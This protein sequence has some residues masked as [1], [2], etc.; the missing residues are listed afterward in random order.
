MSRIAIRAVKLGKTYRIGARQE[1]Y[2]TLRDSLSDVLAL[3]WRALRGRVLSKD[4]AETNT[5]ART[6]ESFEALRDVSFAVEQG[7]V[8]GIIGP[9]GAG[10]STLLK[11]L[12]RI[13][14]PTT[15][16]VDICGRIGSLLEVGTG[17][18][19]ELTGRE[20]IYLN[21]AILGM[22]KWEIERKFDQ[23][24]AFSE[25]D[26]FID[27]PVKHYSSGMY[28]R[29]AFAVAAHL[30]PEILL[31][32]EVL[33]VGDTAFQRK[34]LEKMENV[35][36]QGRTVFFVSHNL[37]AIEHLCQKGIVLRDGRVV[38]NGDA[39]AAVQ[40][41]LRDGLAHD[42][43]SRS[44]VTDLTGAGGRPPG[45]RPLLRKLSLFTDQGES[46][47]KGLRIGASLK[48][49]VEFNLEQPTE[50]FDVG[51]GF[52]SLLGN[53]IFTAHSLFQPNWRD[54]KRTGEQTLICEI[55]SLTLVPGEYKIRV[56][57]NVGGEIA[58]AV[59]DAARIT[60]IGSDY[61]GTGKVPWN[62]TFV[63][64]QHWR[65]ADRN[66]AHSEKPAA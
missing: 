52:D 1:A 19:Q 15:G 7:D 62:G 38:F 16:Y 17:F 4:P 36:R 35:A 27:T 56:T 61:Y 58:D 9:N 64:Q 47:S 55:P 24:V 34:C 57:L 39:R 42:R 12:S 49:C 54:G 66:L 45:S 29:L 21:G 20:N 30:D 13:T 10:K 5:S 48:A 28:L 41:Y 11:I 26:R 60:V 43:A 23:M 32:D 51:L 50:N 40:F 8:V 14:E 2:R 65:L 53:R 44:H 25:I 3:P 6:K 37:A 46:A 18:H 63:L 31:V 22:K 59:E 33:A